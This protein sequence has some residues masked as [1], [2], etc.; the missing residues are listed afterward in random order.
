MNSL[1]EALKEQGIELIGEAQPMY[2]ENYVEWRQL[3]IVRNT[4]Q[5][6]CITWLFDAEWRDIDCDEYPC[7]MWEN[8]CT[9][10]IED[11]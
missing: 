5:E 1:S 8:P 6:I 11:M 4:Q 2:N 10:I 9:W 7:D 3:G